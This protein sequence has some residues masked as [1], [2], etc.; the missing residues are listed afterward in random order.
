MAE[1][2]HP[3]PAD[4]FDLRSGDLFFGASDSSPRKE[5][6]I[7][8]DQRGTP[9]HGGKPKPKEDR[10]ETGGGKMQKAA[11]VL[12]QMAESPAASPLRLQSGVQVLAKAEAPVKSPLTLFAG[13][14]PRQMAQLS[15]RIIRK[16]SEDGT[17]EVSAELLVIV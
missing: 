17:V 10:A 5:V 14:S 8:H 6:P 7:K 12:F 2:V 16:E 9:E 13:T 11:R 1:K 3:E 4:D 15:P